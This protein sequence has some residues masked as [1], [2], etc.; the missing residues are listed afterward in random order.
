MNN[1]THKTQCRSLEQ[2]L[3]M[4]KQKKK[5]T[6]TTPNSCNQ[7]KLAPAN[8]QKLINI[9]NQKLVTM[10][11]P[12][13]IK[14]NNKTHKVQ[15]TSPIYYLSIHKQSQKCTMVTQ[16]S[17]NQRNLAPASFCNKHN[18]AISEL[19]IALKKIILAVKHTVRKLQS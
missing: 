8:L 7:Q 18:I 3:N 19:E 11:S 2:Y 17:C 15:V 1:E 6:V 9:R 14:V 5:R 10:S 12:K 13:K 16:N 4:C